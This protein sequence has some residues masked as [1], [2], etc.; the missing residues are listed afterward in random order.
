M[1]VKTAFSEH[2]DEYDNAKQSAGGEV[3]K[4][5]IDGEDCGEDHGVK[6]GVKG[7]IVGG[8]IGGKSGGVASTARPIWTD[9][10]VVMVVPGALAA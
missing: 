4:D 2:E 6:G 1:P 8:A 7:G 10:V 3:R 5:S 9:R